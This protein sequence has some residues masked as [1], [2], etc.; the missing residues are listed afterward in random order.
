MEMV[1]ILSKMKLSLQL[2]PSF[3][4]KFLETH[5]KDNKFFNL[6]DKESWLCAEFIIYLKASQNWTCHAEITL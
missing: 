3:W 2:K 6:G 4:V 1:T 5:V